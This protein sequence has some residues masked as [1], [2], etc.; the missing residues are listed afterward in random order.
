MRGD[1]RAWNTLVDRYAR[2]VFSIPK[3][4]GFGDSDSDDV[5]QSVFLILFRKLDQ[6][7]DQQRLS[8]WLITTTHRECWRL[9]KKNPVTAGEL[10]RH[11]EDVNEP[12]EEKAQRWEQQHLVQ[13]G[14]AEL[15]GR[16]EALLRMLFLEQGA[17]DYETIA[18]QLDMKVGSI[19][20]TRARCFRKLEAILLEMGVEAPLHVEGR[21]ER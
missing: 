1:Q 2:L 7:Q 6:L 12:S 18:E 5:A 4:Y 14:L 3:R 21:A 17:P 15:G 9:G 16:C 20:P 13:Q 10:D 8:A 19:G 11:I